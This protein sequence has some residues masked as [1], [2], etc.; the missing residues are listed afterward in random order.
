[1]QAGPRAAA[2][3]A[4]LAAAVG[5]GVWLLRRSRA[6]TASASSDEPALAHAPRVQAH[7]NLTRL[8]HE[9]ARLDQP[10]R[11]AELARLLEEALARSAEAAQRAAGKEA[12]AETGASASASASAT[13]SAAA[14]PSASASSSSARRAASV[15]LVLADVRACAEAL[16]REAKRSRDDDVAI[17]CVDVAEET[18][19]ALEAVLDALLHNALLDAQEAAAR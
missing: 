19:P 17:A 2:K 7:A 1:M 18:M 5:A 6:A 11:L 8:V 10:A 13:A 16:L 3:Q 4:S 14:S 15:H 12:G 9:M